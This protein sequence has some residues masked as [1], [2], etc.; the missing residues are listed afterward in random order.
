[1]GRVRRE[2]SG[3]GDGTST[4]DEYGGLAETTPGSTRIRGKCVGPSTSR[5]AEDAV[6]VP[7]LAE[8]LDV[9]GVELL[10]SDLMIAADTVVAVWRAKG[11]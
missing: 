8:R 9:A 11:A 3:R 10:V 1:M 5:Q 4:G 6:T 7:I 2:Q